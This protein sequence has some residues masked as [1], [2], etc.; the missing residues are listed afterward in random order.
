MLSFI[1]WFIHSFS[2]NT[3]ISL[4]WCSKLLRSVGTWF[5]AY[6]STLLMLICYCVF[7]CFYFIMNL[8]C[9][10][11]DLL[12]WCKYQ[13]LLLLLFHLHPYLLPPL[14]SC[15]FYRSS[16][17][18]SSPLLVISSHTPYQTIENKCLFCRNKAE[19]YRKL[20]TWK[21]NISNTNTRFLQYSSFKNCT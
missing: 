15:L 14:C 10:W 18:P 12:N 17:S 8:G 9:G 1:H 2:I 5:R 6:K 13:S 19:V 7:S 21:M 11:L 3:K 16:C 20:H 4:Q